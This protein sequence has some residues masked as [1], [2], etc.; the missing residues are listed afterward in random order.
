MGVES[1]TIQRGEM[2]ATPLLEMDAALPVQWKLD[3]N[4]PL[5]THLLQTCAVLLHEEMAKEIQEKL[6]MTV[7]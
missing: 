2:T 7:N 3:G 6:V 1:E 5:L 4:E